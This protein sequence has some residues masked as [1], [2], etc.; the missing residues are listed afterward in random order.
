MCNT[1]ELARQQ[2]MAVRRCTNFKVGF[3]VGE[4][5]VDDWTRGMWSDEIKKNQVSIG[6]RRHF[7]YTHMI[8]YGLNTT[9]P[10]H[11]AIAITT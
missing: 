4:Q 2:A 10:L 11:T 9:L 7:L 3:Y 1:V 5:G 8:T 6:W